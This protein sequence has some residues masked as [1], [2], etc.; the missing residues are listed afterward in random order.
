MLL[1]L[2]PLKVA[3][4]TIMNNKK[5]VTFQLPDLQDEKLLTLGWRSCSEGGSERVPSVFGSKGGQ[6]LISGCL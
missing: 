3:T 1:S 6:Y 5:Q 4:L 2:W